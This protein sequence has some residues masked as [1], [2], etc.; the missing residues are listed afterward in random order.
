[1]RLI[2]GAN[3]IEYSEIQNKLGVEYISDCK[4]IIIIDPI[5]TCTCIICI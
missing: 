5:N 2:A 4:Y 1:M 3:E